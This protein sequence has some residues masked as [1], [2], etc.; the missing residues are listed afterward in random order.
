MTNHQQWNK[1][2]QIK[3][4]TIYHIQIEH[5]GTDAVGR[6]LAALVEA[7]A[8][9]A[10]ASEAN[11]VDKAAKIHELFGSDSDDD[12]EHETAVGYMFEHVSSVTAV[13]SEHVLNMKRLSVTC[14]RTAR[15]NISW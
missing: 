9:A 12:L 3:I 7:A 2:Y 5:G 10:P 6:R 14:L 13:G 11:S 4:I 15:K 8:A 1:N